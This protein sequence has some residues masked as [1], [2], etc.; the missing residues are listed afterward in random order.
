MKKIF[1]LL[2][3]ASLFSIKSI[4]ADNVEKDALDALDQ[5]IKSLEDLKQE[6][7]AD[8]GSRLGFIDGQG[9]AVAAPPRGPAIATSVESFYSRIIDIGG[10]KYIGA[11]KSSSLYY[12]ADFP[13]QP[14]PARATASGY[15]S[16]IIDRDGQ[17]CLGFDER[18]QLYYNPTLNLNPARQG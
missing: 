16:R 3:L 7:E 9:G 13:L 18:G 8:W 15:Y 12:V 17:K 5:A 1:F 4:C 2:I 11:Q 14:A 6:T 10:T